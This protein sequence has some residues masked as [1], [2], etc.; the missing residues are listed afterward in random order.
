MRGGF[1]LYCVSMLGFPLARETWQLLIPAAVF[2]IGAAVSIP[3]ILTLLADYA[4]E[5]QRG[6]FLS[7]TAMLL[8]LGQT[9]GPI[10]IGAV[11]TLWSVPA[12]FIAGAALSFVTLLVLVVTLPQA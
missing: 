4:P 11:V 12:A 8:R 10:A 9:L 6:A 3:T 2:G 7:L 5:D 1:V